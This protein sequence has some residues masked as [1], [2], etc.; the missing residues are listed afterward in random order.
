MGSNREELEV[1]WDTGS[2][3]FMAKTHICKKCKGTKY[4]YAAEKDGGSF[5]WPSDKY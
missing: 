2:S 5:E 3:V 1:V 4:D